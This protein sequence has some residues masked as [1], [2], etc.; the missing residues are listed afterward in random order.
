MWLAWLNTRRLCDSIL[1]YGS[2]FYGIS[3]RNVERRGLIAAANVGRLLSRLR[4]IL[5]FCRPSDD[6]LLLGTPV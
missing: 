4:K 6:D 5:L 2:G 3:R 1:G